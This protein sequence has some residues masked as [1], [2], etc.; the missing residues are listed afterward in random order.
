MTSAKDPFAVLDRRVY[1]TGRTIFQRGDLGSS[2]LFIKRG[3]VEIFKTGALN[4]SATHPT[5][6]V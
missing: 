2:A 5:G 3:T 6:P 4:R 1:P